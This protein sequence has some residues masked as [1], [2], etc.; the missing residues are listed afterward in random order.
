MLP[1][2]AYVQ[3]MCGECLGR[4]VVS[5]VSVA[6]RACSFPVNFYLT[7]PR[8]TECGSTFSKNE[9]VRKFIGRLTF[10]HT[11][12]FTSPVKQLIVQRS[13]IGIIQ[14]EEMQHLICKFQQVFDLIKF[15]LYRLVKIKVR[16]V[17][18]TFDYIQLSL[19]CN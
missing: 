17:F 16:T 18:I 2:L 4:G 9:N 12:F 11:T 13:F 5:S 8:A 7:H 3:D 15:F 19:I 10:S 14:S 6:C 1:T